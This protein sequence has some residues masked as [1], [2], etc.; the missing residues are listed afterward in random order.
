[1]RVKGEWSKSDLRPEPAKDPDTAYQQFAFLQSVVQGEDFQA[2]V[3][4]ILSR[5]HHRWRLVEEER[6]V[7]SGV[8]AGGNV[9]SAMGRPGP[10][11]TWSHS[12]PGIATVPRS[13]PVPRWDKET[14]VPENRFI[15][16]VL[17][18]RR[19]FTLRVYTILA[20]EQLGPAVERGRRETKAII[21]LLD[22]WLSE[23]LFRRVGRLASI[24]T[25]SLVLQRREGYREI[26]H[27]YL[28]FLSGAKLA[29]PGGND[30]YGA[31]K[32]DVARL[33]QMWVFL[34]MV[35]IILSICNK[36]FDPDDLFQIDRYG[37]E[38]REV[39]LHFD[40][41]YRLDDLAM[42]FRE[43]RS[44]VDEEGGLI[45]HLTQAQRDDLLKMHAYRDAIRRSVGAYVI[46]PGSGDQVL[47]EYHELLPGLGAFALRP[48]SSAG[49]SG[50]NSLG[51]FI[52]DVLD[53]VA[54]QF[55]QHERARYWL[56][57][58]YS[59]GLTLHRPVPA[60][61]FI[62]R[63]PADV[64]TLLGFVRSRYHLNWI[65]KTGRYN[66]R[67]DQR[68]GRVRL[69]GRELAAEIIV[70]YGPELDPPQLWLVTGPPE[71][72]TAQD[73]I[74]SGYPR[75]GGKLYFC[76][77]VEPVAPGNVPVKLRTATIM[78]MINDRYNDAPFGAPV[79]V[80]WFDCIKAHAT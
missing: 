53:H 76:V 69:G 59:R 56:H 58:S 63:P 62:T 44:A 75:P 68:S 8:P 52:N 41:K 20:R 6:L 22:Q 72:W 31:G 43:T 66:V 36:T 34:K 42:L 57:E 9:A 79:A 28:Q 23:P 16:H 74:T 21:D 25:T 3:R 18:A 24:P 13:L 19:D 5:P 78:K 70:L 40:A 38:L 37:M 35:Q 77:P 49:M 45:S 27:M 51:Q 48:A 11:V 29:W 30:V 32:R 15:R 1:M 4:Q 17:E 80:T 67:A 64:P 73:L 47:R 65:Q 39:W 71:V 60:T 50:I 33:Y 61:P 12:T 55:T 2:A 7:G 26:F 14:D 10:R 54:S 46:Y